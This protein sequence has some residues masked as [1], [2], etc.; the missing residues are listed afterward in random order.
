MLVRSRIQSR[1]SWS[2]INGIQAQEAEVRRDIGSIAGE[3]VPLHANLIL[4]LHIARI[5]AG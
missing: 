5:R 3:W 1:V 4:R 2:V